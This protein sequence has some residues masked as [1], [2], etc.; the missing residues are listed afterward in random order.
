MVIRAM[1]DKKEPDREKLRELAFIDDLTSLYNRRYLYRYLPAQLKDMQRAGKP[2][3]LLIMD[4]DTFKKIN[5][6]YGH[7][8]GDK[9]LVQIAEILRKSFREKDTVIRYAGDEFV[10]LLPDTERQTALDRGKGIIKKIDKSLFRESEGKHNIHITLTM[11]LAVFP[12]DAKDPEKLIRQADKALYSAKQGGRN[13]ICITED[14][15]EEVLDE[16]RLQEIFPCPQLIGRQDQLQ[17]LRELLDE[18]QKGES[19]FAI[20][21]GARGIGKSRLINELKK[22]AQLK[23]LTNISASCSP[24]I[25]NQPYQTLIMVLENLF[26]SLGAQVREFIRSLPEAQTGQLANYIPALKQFLPENLKAVRASSNK[27]GQID[28]FKGICQSL[29]Y[30]VKRTPLLLIIDDFQWVDKETLHLFDYIIKNLRNIPILIA[31]ACRDEELEKR[32]GTTPSPKELLRRME[33]DGLIKEFFLKP[34]EKEEIF[35]IITSIFAG[36]QLSPK[37][38]D[39]VYDVST[40]NPLFT[41]EVLRSLVNKGFIVYQDGKWHSREIDQAALPSFLK[42]TIQR[43]LTDL[44]EETKPVISAAAVIGEVFDFDTLCQLLKKDAGYILEVIDRAVRQHLIIPESPFQTDIFKFNSGLIRDVIYAD[45]NLQEK[46]D[47]HRKLAL[48]EEKAY[49]DNIDSVAGSLGYHFGKAQ[50]MKKA[51]LYSDMLLEKAKRMP[52]YTDASD[53]LQ[54]AFLAKVE[55]IVIP[56]TD[57]S[58]KLV[59]AMVRALRLA[60]QNVRLYPCHSAIREG[61]VAQAFKYLTDILVKDNTLTLSTAENRLLINGE[62]ISEKTSRSAGAEAF[63]TLM[64]EHRIKSITFNKD[65]AREQFVLFLESLSLNYDDL[66]PEG[67]LSKMLRKN[68][69]SHIKVNEVRYEQTTK[70][71]KQRVQFEDAML[72]DYLIGKVS[73]VEG[74]KGEIAAMQ[75]ANDPKRLTQALNKIA[76]ETKP[77]KDQDKTLAQAN[78]IARSLQ[79][80]GVRVFSQTESEREEYLKKIADAIR[81]LGVKLRYKLIQV[82]GEA[83][84]IGSRDIIEEA[85]REF[86]DEEVLEMLTGVFSDSQG[87]LTDIRSFLRRFLLDPRRKQGLLPKLKAKLFQLGMKEEEAS[88]ALQENLWEGLS[89]KEKVERITKLSARDYVRLEVSKPIVDLVWQLLGKDQ[90][91]QVSEVIDKLLGQLE[92][93]SKQVRS[94]T[95]NDL[96]KICERLVAKEKYFLL[97]GIIN[98]LTS[99]L[100]KEKDPQVYSLLSRVLATICANLIK[101]QNFIQ[102]AGVLKEFNLRLKKTSE[103]LDIQK[104]T[105]KNAKDQKIASPQIL[106]WL[107]ELLKEKVEGHHDFW[108]LSKLIFEIGPVTISPMFALTIPRDLYVDPFKTYT[109]RWS[110]AKVLKGMGDEAVFYLKDKLLDRRREVVKVALKLF[111]H[112]Q[113]EK[114]LKYLGPLLKHKDLDVRKEVIATLGK[115][116]GGEAVKLLSECLRDE[117]SQIRLAAIRALADVRGPDVLGLLEPLLK[118]GQLSEEARRITRRI[119]ERT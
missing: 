111:G 5:D 114:A 112:I 29:S 105:I 77:Q 42:E 22:H 107:T 88:S 49:K 67:G 64:I 23:G 37:F 32:T 108:E 102:A 46:Q 21:K 30:I 50:D 80:L 101:K 44:D 27:Q 109:L 65:L 39:I 3:C 95:L 106:D 117:N 97:E 84:I 87:N 47:L 75:A 89:L 48:I 100:N 98:G 15:R 94:L 43:R 31:A 116:G 38:A 34:L 58:M 17:R 86:S 35:K 1:E 82:E 68:G 70:L 11:G 61:F 73:N 33:K 9:L 74:N 55:E 60:V 63:I 40:G 90:Y 69:V 119:A 104:E 28:L 18:A 92:D 26:V 66:I 91:G 56:L 78:M 62:E 12:D 16:T 85:L 20:V 4:V 110:I 93:E 72:I 57:A 14:I 71:T 41:E 6:T 83:G 19:R 79:R 115:I 113:N 76:E 51:A 52:A 54:E 10:A 2:L 36:I 81:G 13:R 8:C 7:L 45:L 118:D 53:F 25:S 99:R 103:L 24:E 96:D 59:A